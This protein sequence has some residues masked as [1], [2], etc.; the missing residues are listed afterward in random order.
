MITDELIPDFLLN[1]YLF[2]RREII[3]IHRIKKITEIGGREPPW[4]FSFELKTH[5]RSFILFAPTIEE[6]DLW[7][8]G[9]NRILQIPVIDPNFVPMGNLTKSQLNNIHD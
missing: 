8:N 6:R 1:L 4:Y 7:V 5:D 9:F 2:V 3:C